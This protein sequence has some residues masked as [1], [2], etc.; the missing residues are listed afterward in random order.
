MDELYEDAQSEG[1]WGTGLPFF[2]SDQIQLV[3]RSTPGMEEENEDP[4]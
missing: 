4:W 3:S 1:F 2:T